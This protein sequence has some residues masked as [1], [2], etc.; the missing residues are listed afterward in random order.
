MVIYI[1]R[2][3]YLSPYNCC[4]WVGAGGLH[5]IHVL[6]VMAVYHLRENHTVTLF[7]LRLKSR[8]QLREWSLG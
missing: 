8:Y 3:C 7:E 2:L 5:Y 1:L 6:I 4:V